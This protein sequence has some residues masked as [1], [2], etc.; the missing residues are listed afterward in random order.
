MILEKVIREMKIGPNSIEEREE[1]DTIKSLSIIRSNISQC[2]NKSITFI[3]E[4]KA[5][6]IVIIYFI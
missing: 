6:E 5:L 2:S 1:F 4:K 3:I